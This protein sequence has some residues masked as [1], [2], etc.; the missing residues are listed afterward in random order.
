MKKGKEFPARRWMT[1]LTALL[2][3]ALLSVPAMALEARDGEVTIQAAEIVE[4]GDGKTITVA[5]DNQSGRTVRLGWG[6]DCT[7]SVT[8]S[9]GT[10]SLRISGITID[11]P[12]QIVSGTSTQTFTVSPCP[13]EV[14]QIVLTSLRALE[15]GSQLPD[16]QLNEAVIYQADDPDGYIWDIDAAAEQ[17]AAEE[18][19]WQSHL[20]SMNQTV[21][22]FQE[23]AEDY[24]GGFG[25]GILE[26]QRSIFSGIQW[27]A[28]FSGIFVLI[29]FCVIAWN[30]LYPNSTVRKKIRLERLAVQRRL[31]EE[32]RYASGKKQGRR[33]GKV[34]PSENAA[35]MLRQNQEQLERYW[36]R[37]CDR[38]DEARSQPEDISIMEE[39]QGIARNLLT[40]MVRGIWLSRTG[41]QMQEQ[42]EENR[43]EMQINRLADNGYITLKSRGNY[44]QIRK[45]CNAGAHAEWTGSKP[46]ELFYLVAKEVG[47][48]IVSY[49][50]YLRG[51]CQNY[52]A[53]KL[54][55]EE[56]Q[57]MDGTALWQFIREMLAG[58]DAE[59]LFGGTFHAE[60]DESS[61][62]EAS[63]RNQWFQQQVQQQFQQQVQQFQQQAQQFQQQQVDQF[64]WQS[65]NT[66]PDGGFIPPP[67]PPPIN[68]N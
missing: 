44:H 54:P 36:K 15:P 50:Q 46:E 14:E 42:G 10:Y 66:I 53:G 37:Y 51:V 32:E 3:A 34:P 33:T 11:G 41:T 59:K 6:G 16:Y 45:I 35:A 4:D 62:A 13:G 65:A 38:T 23:A 49:N 5:F 60:H 39:A 55:A 64:N 58:V 7:L 19:A 25:A 21:Q 26:M 9:E 8:T 18:E 27:G 31:D 24:A 30:L 43:L 22:E 57:R 47:L 61:A 2:V 29:I 12:I 52:L 1:A 67:T 20:D 28:I 63:W 40:A 68:P 56:A 17:E 48:C